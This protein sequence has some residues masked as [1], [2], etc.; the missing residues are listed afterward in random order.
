MTNNNLIEVGMVITKASLQA[1]GS[2]R[3]Q[4]VTSDTSPDNTGESTSLSLFQDW[5]E[6]AETG[7]TVDWLPPPTQAVLRRFALFRP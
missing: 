4:A 7:E 6:R 3:W 1:D 5:I 2:M